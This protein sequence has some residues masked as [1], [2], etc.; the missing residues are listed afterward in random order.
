VIVLSILFRQFYWFPGFRVSSLPLQ[1]V[2]RL[3]PWAT[4]M[5]AVPCAG[6]LGWMFPPLT[7]IQISKLPGFSNLV[8]AGARAGFNVEKIANYG[9]A[10]V[11]ARRLVGALACLLIYS[12]LQYTD[13]S[14]EAFLEKYGITKEQSQYSF[15]CFFRSDQALSFIHSFVSG[16]KFA[17]L[18]AAAFFSFP[19]TPLSLFLLP[20]VV[21][22]I[23]RYVWFLYVVINPHTCSC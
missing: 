8:S 11:V 2:A 7:R 12:V 13:A 3:A 20:S 1:G 9:A 5:A 21:P 17:N 10:L 19:F 4:W 6:V 18:G 14:P 22:R 15:V 16:R 23:A